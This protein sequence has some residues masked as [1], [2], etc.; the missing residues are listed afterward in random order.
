[1]ARGRGVCRHL[2]GTKAPEDEEAHKIR[3]YDF[4]SGRLVALLKGH[5]DVVLGLAFSPD[6]PA[7]DLGERRHHRHNLGCRRPPG[8]PPAHRHHGD[9]Y[10]V[11]FSPDGARAVTGSLDH[12]LRLWR[13][14]DGGEIARMT[15]HGDNVMSLAVAA[16]G[17]TVSG[18]RSGEIRLW[19]G[20]TGRFRK[21]LAWQG[22]S[23]GSLSFSPDGRRLLS[24]VGPG[25]NNDCHVYEVASGRE[26]ATYRGHDNIVL[27]TTISPDG[28]WAATGGG[29]SFPIHIWDVKTGQRRAGPDGQSLTLG[30]Q[31][32]SVWGVGFSEDGRR[33][34]WGSVGMTAINQATQLEHALTLPSTAEALPRP[35]PLTETQASSFRRA[36]AS[37][38]G[39]TLRHRTG[40]NFGYY[41]VLDIKQGGRVRASIERG[42]TDGYDHRSYSFTPDGETVISGGANGWLTAYDRAGNTLGDF[43]GHEADVW[44]VAPSPD[45]RFLLSGAADQTVRLW[46]LKT[47]ELLITLFY[48]QD[49]EW[50]MS[51]PRGYFIGSPGGEKLIGWHVDRGPDKAADFFPVGQFRAQSYRPD[52][53]A[54]TVELG[55]ESQAITRA[56]QEQQHRE[57]ESVRDQLPPA[58]TIDKPAD[59]DDFST[60]VLTIDYTLRSP[61]GLPVMRVRALIDGRPVEGAITKGFVPVRTEAETRGRLTVSVP[62][63]DIALSLIAETGRAESV[64]ATRRLHWTGL[65]ESDLRK[66]VL[67]ALVVG[68][69]AYKDTLI[70]QLSWA[71]DDARDFA[72]A[73]QKQEGGLYR[74]VE[75]KLLINDEALRAAVID[76][77]EWL[78]GSVS[79]GDVGVVFLSGHGGTDASRKFL[80]APH[81]AVLDADAGLRLPKRSTAVPDTEILDALN[82]LRGHALFFFDT[83]HA[84][85]A[86]G[87]RFKGESDYQPFVAE[88]AAAGTGV[89]V[90]AS[91]D[92]TELSQ[93]RDEW[94][95]GAFTKALLEGVDGKADLVGNDGII[96]IDELGLF[97][98]DRV[99][100]LTAGQQHP[101]D[102]RPTETRNLAFASVRP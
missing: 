44:A 96:T 77:L 33:T 18:D 75:M 12:D 101:V 95:H 79:Q 70:S 78:K 97:V 93:E 59:G 37:Q 8:P 14:A 43:T 30:G 54:L 10:A 85:R 62:Q 55:D 22:T 21:T 81:D 23:I 63:R 15:G 7:S 24:G 87:M 47:R 42:P 100:A 20:R 19:D 73:L 26:I 34:G 38:G 89:M 45:G 52:I 94:R 92:G 58:I 6:G 84:G 99:K 51:T 31:G 98:K 61:S 40:G 2:H 35:E 65:T 1:M 17:A 68:V 32:Q 13:V 66:P 4:T 57:A 11:G 48:G 9:I 80:F 90:L 28:R 83:C 50:V 41:A 5:E 60:D 102:L 39:W 36:A 53:V 64:P 46:N 88:L 86:A 16:D 82:A 91:S 74:R 69:N 49:G 72:A 67:Y 56:N 76:G 27:A 29:D 25:P 3:L 71:G